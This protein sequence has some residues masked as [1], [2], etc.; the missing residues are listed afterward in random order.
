MGPRVRPACSSLT[1]WLDDPSCGDRLKDWCALRCLAMRACGSLSGRT[2]AGLVSLVEE[3]EK[4]V[5][6]VRTEMGNSANVRALH[7][8]FSEKGPGD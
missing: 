3:G 8:L 2:S 6:A 4:K 5:N 7:S 1:I